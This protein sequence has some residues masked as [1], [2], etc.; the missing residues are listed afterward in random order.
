MQARPTLAVAGLP[1]CSRPIM[2]L[3][4]RWLPDAKRAG[5]T[6]RRAGAVLLLAGGLALVAGCGSTAKRPLVYAAETFGVSSAHARGFPVAMP[7]TCEA[8]RRALLSNGYIVSRAAPDTIDGRKSFQPSPDAHVEITVHVVCA[9]EGRERSTVFANAL[10]DRYELKKTSTSASLGVG[11][12]GS[13]SL[14]FGSSNDSMVKVASE[15]IVTASFYERF[16]ALIE[17]YLAMRDE[18]SAEPT[19]TT[20]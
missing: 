11:P 20:Q 19:A 3:L 7:Q 15:T 14:P 17:H 9:D 13:V 6:G 18:D 4:P 1:Y 8:A 2:P 12:V 5:P 16:F 10:Q